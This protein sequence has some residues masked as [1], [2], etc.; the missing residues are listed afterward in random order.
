MSFLSCSTDSTIQN[1]D[2]NGNSSTTTG[3]DPTGTT[4]VYA[5]SKNTASLTMGEEL[6]LSITKNGNAISGITWTSSDTDLARVDSTGL[7][8]ACFFTN[9]NE[10]VTITGKVNND[11]SLTCSL[12]IYPR[13]ESIFTQCYY[14]RPNSINQDENGHVIY[15]FVHAGLEANGTLLVNKTFEYDSYT[16]IC[17]IKVSKSYEQ[18]GVTAYY[19]GYNTFYWGSYQTGLFY[20]YYVEVVNGVQKSAEFDFDKFGFDY[21][22]HTIY[23]TNSTTYTV[24]EKDWNTITDEA[25][26]AKGVFYRIQECSEFAEEKFT[27][28]NY[29]I[30][31]F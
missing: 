24:V 26:V 31:L 9:E 25:M 7:V 22:T 2:N 5:I 21:D 11:L 12:T 29:G 28:Y 14:N 15:M 16:N 17:N 19:I 13:E 23:L 4:D 8:R 10:P 18:S 30:H 3:G 27:E 20:G 6:Q 1:D